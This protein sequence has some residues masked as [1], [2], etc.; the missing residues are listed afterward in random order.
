MPETRSH[1]VSWEIREPDPDAAGLSGL[2]IMR[3][4]IARDSRHNPIAQLM[5]IRLISAEPGVAVLE[6]FPGEHHYNPQG[7]THGGYAATL[8]DSALWSAVNTTIEP[9]FTHTTLEL[10]VSYARPITVATG[11][12]LIE[13][14]VLSR[15]KRV[16]LTEAKITDEAGKLYAHGTSTLLIIPKAA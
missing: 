10:K 3:R 15:G 6:S 4:N 2:E 5:G 13:G 9:G 7:V 8:L 16:A 11:R 12:L 1:T 14:R